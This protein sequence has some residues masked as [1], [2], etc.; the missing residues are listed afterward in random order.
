M[1]EKNYVVR[2]KDE[3]PK[4]AGWY[5]AARKGYEIPMPVRV[6]ETLL[7]ELL[8]NDGERCG[9]SRHDYD[10]FGPVLRCLTPEMEYAEFG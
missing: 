3:V 1:A 7:A 8:V 2:Q 9:Q 4:S 6:Y 5:Y 10:W